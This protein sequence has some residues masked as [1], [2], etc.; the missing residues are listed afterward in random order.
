M[1]LR[2]AIKLLIDHQQWR[3]GN[4]DYP[5]QVPSEITEALD[6]VLNHCVGTLELPQQ[7][8]LYTEEQV[9]EGLRFLFMKEEVELIMNHLNNLKKI[10]YDINRNTHK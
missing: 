3:L 1:T 6:I 9:R 2:E 4:D 7:E 10:N 5:M 8:T